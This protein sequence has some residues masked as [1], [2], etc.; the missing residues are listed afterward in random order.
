MQTKW[1]PGLTRGS[2]L[3]MTRMAKQANRGW[4]L[5]RDWM[6]EVSATMSSYYGARLCLGGCL[7]PETPNAWWWTIESAIEGRRRD[8][9]LQVSSLVSGLNTQY[10]YFYAHGAFSTGGVPVGRGQ[11]R[12]P[13]MPMRWSENKQDRIQQSIVEGLFGLR[14]CLPRPATEHKG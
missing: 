2:K 12:T 5:T 13:Q 6:G 1:A 4:T 10:D 14:S 11:L 7:T 3:T 9:D 8:L